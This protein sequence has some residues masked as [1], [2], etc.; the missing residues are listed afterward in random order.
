LFPGDV[1]LQY[2]DGQ[3]A[4]QGQRLDGGE[5]A[6]LSPPNLRWFRVGAPRRSP[7]SVQLEVP[8]VI[9]HEKLQQDRRE[10]VQGFVAAAGLLGEKLLRTKFQPGSRAYPKAGGKRLPVGGNKPKIVVSGRGRGDWPVSLGNPEAAMRVF[11]T[12]PS[13]RQPLSIPD[14]E[15]G[16]QVRCPRCHAVFHA[17]I[18]A[19]AAA[20]PP[21]RRTLPRRGP[22]ALLDMATSEAGV[23]LAVTG[24]ALT[25]TLLAMV[26]Q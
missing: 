24:A 6:L 8:K 14:Y 25:L 15:A 1:H 22:S 17:P 18:L 12:C 3:L 5:V 19:P 13:C 23:I 4:H 11:F 20:G 2:W 7:L 21:V 10:E 9:T 16:E 26:W